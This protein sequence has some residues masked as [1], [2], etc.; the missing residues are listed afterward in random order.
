MKSSEHAAAKINL[1]LEILG[2]RPDGYHELRSLVVFA[3]SACD[4]LNLSRDQAGETEAR[5]PFASHLNGA[6]LIDKAIAAFFAPDTPP[7]GQILLLL[8]K[9]LPVASGIGGGSADAAAT[10]RLLAAAF[11]G[12]G[13]RDLAS[14]AATLGADVPVCLR[15]RAAMMT[16]IGEAVAPLDLPS[17]LYAVLANAQAD[18]PHNKTQAVFKLLAADRLRPADEPESIPH[19]SSFGDVVVYAAARGNHLEAPAKRL[20]PE[21]ANV[22][23]ELRELGGVKLAQLSGAGPTCFALFETL[24]SADAAAATLLRRQPTWW[25]KPTRLI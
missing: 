25:V 16:G 23:S 1:T 2:R 8:E 19:L 3:E 12:V 9:N 24:Q 21:I 14:I 13:E 15:S 17:N 18:V 10:L 5:G 7:T 6:D 20:M 11:P 4:V 22:L